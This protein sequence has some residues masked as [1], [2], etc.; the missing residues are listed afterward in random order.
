MRKHKQTWLAFCF[1]QAASVFLKW[2]TRQTFPVCHI[3]GITPSLRRSRRTN[4]WNTHCRN[5]K[6]SSEPNEFL[7]HNPD[8]SFVI[9]VGEKNAPRCQ[10]FQSRR[11]TKKV[12]KI[13]TF[14]QVF[15]ELLSGAS[16]PPPPIP[17]IHC[18]SLVENNWNWLKWLKVGKRLY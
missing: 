18:I 14:F 10:T 3:V 12:E 11:W 2:S 17:K 6:E 1:P 15:L 9:S 4:R 5:P 16:S 7:S 8:L 13:K